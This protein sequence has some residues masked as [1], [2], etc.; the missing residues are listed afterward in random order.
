[1]TCQRN[2][3]N[4]G[5][6]SLVKHFAI[7]SMFKIDYLLKFLL[8]LTF[9]TLAQKSLIYAGLQV[10]VKIRKKPESRTTSRFLAKGAEKELLSNII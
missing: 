10:L 3:E 4:G 2:E 5:H 9:S 8:L 1:M 7:R 6:S